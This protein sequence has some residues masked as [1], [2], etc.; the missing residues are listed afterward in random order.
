MKDLIKKVLTE[1]LLTEGDH[2]ILYDKYEFDGAS[3]SHFKTGT[4]VF[5]DNSVNIVNDTFQ[6][7][8]CIENTDICIPFTTLVHGVN[9]Y[10]VPQWDKDGKQ[11]LKISINGNL[12]LTLKDFEKYLK[13]YDLGSSDINLDDIAARIKTEKLFLST[14]NEI[15][16]NIY[17]KLKSED[18]EP[19]FGESVKDDKCKTNRGVINFRGVKY[20]VGYKLVSDWSILNYFNTNSGVIKFLLRE[21]MNV[22]EVNLSDFTKNFKNEQTKFINW[23]KKN[24]VYL[25]GP[26]SQF[27][28]KMERINLTSLN[29]GIQREQQAVMIL[30]KLHNLG[31]EGITEYCPGSI[32][33]TIYGRDVRINLETPIYY[34]IKPLNGLIKKTENGYLVPTHSMKR[35]PKTVDKFIFVG[36]NGKYII[37]Q[38]ENYEVSK[39]GDFVT[40]KNE[41]ITQN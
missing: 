30:M 37:F 28:D 23:I 34:Q 13:G 26:E 9:E 6:D 24:Q 1:H 40:F 2:P 21:Y 11:I 38:N 20:G 8:E 16:E 5:L 35:Y 36:K 15:M 17:S 22:T 33:D 3:V 14:L 31:E 25:F 19:L 10:R 27:L 41:P 4:N 12:Y 29:S 18:G 32:E 7:T 39:K